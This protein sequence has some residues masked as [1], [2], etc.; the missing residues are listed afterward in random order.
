MRPRVFV[1][2]GKDLREVVLDIETVS[3]CDNSDLHANT[4]PEFTESLTK[5]VVMHG[6]PLVTEQMSLSCCLIVGILDGSNALQK[7]YAVPAH[8]AQRTTQP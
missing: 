4:C 2:F 7:T 1:G 3:G 6:P 5:P 8:D